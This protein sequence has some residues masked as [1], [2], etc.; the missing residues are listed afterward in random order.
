MNSGT[1]PCYIK[2]SSVG[3]MYK[4]LGCGMVAEAAGV[5]AIHWKA[6]NVTHLN[7][8]GPVQLLIQLRHKGFQV[9]PQV[10]LALHWGG[11]WWRRLTTRVLSQQAWV[12]TSNERRCL[13]LAG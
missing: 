8:F 3:P 6:S 11:C 10:P 12:E 1:K 2:L 9:M 4:H 7:P 5:A 13:Q